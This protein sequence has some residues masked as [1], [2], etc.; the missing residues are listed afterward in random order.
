MSSI[1]NNRISSR[2]GTSLDSSLEHVG[3]RTAATLEMVKDK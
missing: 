3:F 2:M 1:V